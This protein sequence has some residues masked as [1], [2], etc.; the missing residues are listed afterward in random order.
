MTLEKISL[1]QADGALLAHVAEL[2]IDKNSAEAWTPSQYQSALTSPGVLAKIFYEVD[3]P[4]GFW[5]GR[6]IG[7]EAEI[8][9]IA[10][11]RDYR[12]Q[13]LG[14]HILKDAVD[15]YRHVGVQNLHLEVREHNL[16]AQNLYIHLGFQYVGRRPKYY[17]LAN[18]HHEDALNMTCDLMRKTSQSL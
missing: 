16:A 18:G 13:G 15:Y 14:Q 3:E 12:R 6:K 4:K 7:D 5:L 10:S 17:R 8:L 1:G 9:L 2:C 11:H